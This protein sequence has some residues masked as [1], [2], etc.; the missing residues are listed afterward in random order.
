[1]L[2][3]D[4]YAHIVDFLPDEYVCVLKL[5]SKMF[6]SIP[7]VQLSHLHR[8]GFWAARNGYLQLCKRVYRIKDGSK[9]CDEAA[10]HGHLDILNWLH[11]KGAPM[12]QLVMSYAAYGGNIHILE[13]L[14]Q[15]NVDKNIFACVDAARGGHMHVL[16][17]LRQRDYPWDPMVCA[18]AAKSGH[19]EILKYL[20]A[21]GCPCGND[22]VIH[23][24]Y[25]RHHHVLLWFKEKGYPIDDY[26]IS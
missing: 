1:M 8:I 5:V 26:L 14:H 17:W 2:Y 12:D 21:E 7:R 9:L 10:E 16:K 6:A 4:I 24:A 3:K 19:L 22:A 25:N 11:Q 13:Y 23:A 18:S 20:I 15:L